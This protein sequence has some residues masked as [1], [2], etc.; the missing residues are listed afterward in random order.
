LEQFQP[1][2]PTKKVVPMA[3][4]ALMGVS[5]ASVR[6]VYVLL[7]RVILF[8]FQNARERPGLAIRLGGVSSVSGGTDF[9]RAA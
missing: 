6:V 7:F 3:V 5:V 4:Q 8:G 1:Q 9:F 2:A